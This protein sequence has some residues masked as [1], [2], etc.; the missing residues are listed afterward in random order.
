M[1]QGEGMIDS[2]CTNIEE[3]RVT[4]SNGVTMGHALIRFIRCIPKHF[5]FHIALMC[6]ALD[7]DCTAPQNASLII[8]VRFMLHGIDIIDEIH[9]YDV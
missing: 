4:S 7:N 1:Y 6:G 3:H 2:F 5:D 9:A 8:F